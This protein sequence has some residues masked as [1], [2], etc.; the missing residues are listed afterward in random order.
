[1]QGRDPA[2]PFHDL[3]RELLRTGIAAEVPAR[4]PA[5]QGHASSRRLPRTAGACS[6]PTSW[7]GRPHRDRCDE[8][9]GTLNQL[10]PCVSWSLASAPAAH[11]SMLAGCPGGRNIRWRDPDQT[12]LEHVKPAAGQG[13]HDVA[14]AA[15]VGETRARELPVGDERLVRVVRKRA[16]DL[17]QQPQECHVGCGR[18]VGVAEVE[19]RLRQRSRGDRARGAALVRSERRANRRTGAAGRR[20]RSDRARGRDGPSRSSHRPGR[21]PHHRVPDRSVPRRPPTR[22]THDRVV[23]YR[24][25]RPRSSRDTDAVVVGSPQ[26]GRIEEP[27][28]AAVL[29][30]GR[31]L[32]Q[33][34]LPA[35]RGSDQPVRRTDHRES[36]GRV[37]L[38]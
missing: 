4:R 26:I 33:I 36:V 16:G 12:C 32:D 2:R 10:E 30:H 14:S 6:T 5:P 28:G 22:A 37:L 9:A 7:N 38:R 15:L 8:S 18:C 35:L 21:T 11:P 34:P 1:M 20:R 24:A 19:D 13:I 27:V 31:T 25:R 23:S 17:V 29:D 3:P